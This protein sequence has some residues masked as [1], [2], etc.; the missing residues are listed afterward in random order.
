MRKWEKVKY[1]GDI[2]ILSLG[3]LG[4]MIAGFVQGF[5]ASEVVVAICL[6]ALALVKTFTYVAREKQKGG[7]GNG[8]RK[9][10]VAPPQRDP[11]DRTDQ[12]DANPA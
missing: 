7:R 8:L 4:V 11:L 1:E 3:A 12:Q 9:M 6:L 5:R 10:R 2:I